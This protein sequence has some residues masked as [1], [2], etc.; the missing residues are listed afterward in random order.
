MRA[1]RAH[2]GDGTAYLSAGRRWTVRM[3]WR[4]GGPLDRLRSLL[5]RLPP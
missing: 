1:V 3:D 2:R 5:G 4:D